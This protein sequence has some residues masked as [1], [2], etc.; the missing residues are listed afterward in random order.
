[1]EYA[2]LM[3]IVIFVT[4]QN[5]MSKK[6][7]VDIRHQNVFLF[8]AVT[9]FAALIFFLVSSGFRLDFNIEFLPYSL[10]FALAHSSASIGLV[11]AIKY[12]SLS[13]T[14]LIISYSLLLPTLHGII[15]LDERLGSTSY[16]GMGLLLISLFLVNIKKEDVKL[17]ALWVVFTVITFIGNGMCSVV[18]KIEQTVFDGA[19][20]SE[21]MMVAL[22]ASAV[23]SLVLGLVSAKSLKQ[24]IK[25]TLSCGIAK[26]LANGATNLLVM[27]ITGALASSVVFPTISAGGIVLTFIIAVT[28]YKERLSKLQLL[29]YAAGIISVI[30]LNI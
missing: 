3:L 19:Y 17:S 26:G 4:V 27:I 11:L 22:F 16:I 18:Q 24:E 1:M 14:S 20:K 5:V 23:V 30:L 21:F 7:N 28:V 13:I 8:N 12:G 2:L 29:G 10:L 9:A 15:F 6:Y 25:G